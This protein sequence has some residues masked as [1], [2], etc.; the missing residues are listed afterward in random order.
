M[1][2]STLL[3]LV[4]C[5]TPEAPKPAPAP[6]VAAPAPT[7]TPMPMSPDMKMEPGTTMPSGMPMAAPSG[8]EKEEADAGPATVIP[9]T[10]AAIVTEMQARE[11][12][13]KDLL[14]AGQLK[15][16]HAQ[17]KVV[18]DLAVAAPSKAPAASQAKVAL[19][20]LDLKKEADELHDLADEGNAAGAKTAFD[21]MSADIAFL[22]AVSG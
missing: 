4:A 5:S 8:E 9:D 22:A 14:A 2:L 1:I 7:P 13:I 19:K 11:A 15:D 6:Q 18:M 16:V 20:A 12:K 10:Y 3:A 17:A 21:A